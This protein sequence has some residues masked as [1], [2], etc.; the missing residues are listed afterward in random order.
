M[1]DVYVADASEGP[2]VPHALGLQAGHDVVVLD[3]L[4]N[5]SPEA[6]ARVARIA[7]RAPQFVRGDVRDTALL[8][9]RDNPTGY[10]SVGTSPA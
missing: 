6:L 10:A 4:S 1:L 3:N 5:S 2:Y 9:Q 8:Q 7:G